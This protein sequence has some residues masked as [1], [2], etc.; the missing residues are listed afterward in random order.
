MD[1]FL[2]DSALDDPTN[3][4]IVTRL[5][6]ISDASLVFVQA[7][8][9]EDSDRT[10]LRLEANGDQLINTVASQSNNT[11]VVVHTVGP[12]LMDWFDHPNITA[13]VFPHLPG[14]ESGSS[15]AK[16]LY[17]DINPSGKMP[18]SVL[19]SNDTD[20]YNPIVRT[21][22]DDGTI[23]VEFS[24]GLYIDYRQFDRDGLEPLIHFGH[25]KSYTTFKHSSS[26]QAEVVTDGS[27]YPTELSES[28]KSGQGD[29]MP[30]GLNS[31]WKYAV[32]LDVQVAN[33]G[34]WDG[35]EVSQLYIQFPD[36]APDTPRKQ[37]VGFQKLF[38]NKGESKYATFQVTYRDMSYW[39]VEQQKFVVPDGDFTFR[40]GSSSADN[41]LVAEV[42]VKVVDGKVQG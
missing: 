19:S 20:A 21:T 26:L 35:A 30:G 34:D 41:E 22:N 3:Q 6:Q 28:S 37:L 42:K 10:S 31:L 33:T 29:I 32:K 24:E 18:Y 11:I 9:G 38:I 5:A 12:I 17:G 2:E 13:L 25:G 39:S 8:S 4:D 16:V 7:R 1:S 23:P 40:A 15:L 36:S 14:Q 27:C